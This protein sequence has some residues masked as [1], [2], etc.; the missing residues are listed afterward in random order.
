MSTPAPPL[1]APRL[2]RIT[3]ALMAVA[4]V[5]VLV[6]H[7]PAALLAA[8]LVYA[9]VGS[10]AASLRRHLSGMHAHWLVV[11]LLVAAVVGLITALIVAAIAL[12]NSEH[13]NPMLLLERVTPLLDRA[14][15]QLPQSLVQY[16]PANPDDIRAAVLEWL[17]EHAAQLQGTGRD[18]ARTFV[19]IIIGIVLGAMIALHRARKIPARGPLSTEIAMRANTLVT[20]FRDVVYAQAKISALNTLLT[21]LYLLVV[22]PLFGVHLPLAKTLVVATFIL[23]LL[24]VVGNLMSNALIFVI[25]L[26]VSLG[27]A[28]SALGYLI[29]I[30]KLEY[31]L[32]ARIIGTQIRANAFE[33]LIAMLVMEG[34]F[35]VPGLIVAPIYYAYLKREL[36]SERL[37]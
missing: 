36:E 2:R 6:A 23:G 13:G 10:L 19:Q 17:R 5:V 30:H 35:G 31:F 24:P 32:N 14:R 37:I 28:L 26:S 33:L 25:G 21:G 16:L 1:P 7:L 18:A 20:A 15:T 27:V 22:L 11:A 29:V 9:L 12:F 34:V 8:L 3:Q 4:L